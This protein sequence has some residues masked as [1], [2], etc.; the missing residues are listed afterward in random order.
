[1]LTLTSWQAKRNAINIQYL[2]VFH[3]KTIWFQMGGSP[4]DKIEMQLQHKIDV[5]FA[6]TDNKTN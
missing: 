5:S 6:A 3:S 2:H 1:M 4:H